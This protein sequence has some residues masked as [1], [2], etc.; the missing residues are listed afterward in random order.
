LVIGDGTDGSVT[1]AGGATLNVVSTGIGSSA[2]TV[3]THDGG[4]GEL[5]IDGAGTKVTVGSSMSIGAGGTGVVNVTGGASLDV[6]GM[7]LNVGDSYQDPNNSSIYGSGVLNISGAGTVVTVAANRI[8]LGYLGGSGELNVTDGATLNSGISVGNLGTG[9][10]VIAGAGTTVNGSVTT[11]FHSLTTIR[12]G[13]TVNGNISVN[14]GIVNVGAAP[15]EAATLVHMDGVDALVSNYGVLNLNHTG[16]IKF[17]NV[18]S[19]F[20]SNNP[21]LNTLNQIAGTTI[22]TGSSGA[23]GLVV[24]ITGGTLQIGDSTDA[25]AGLTGSLDAHVIH[26]DATLVLDRADTSGKKL[27]NFATTVDG[28]GKLVKQGVGTITL[29]GNNSYTGG[30]EINAGTLVVAADHALGA[31]SSAVTLNGGTLQV[32]KGIILTHDLVLGAN[33]GSVTMGGNVDVSGA[34]RG[35][36]SF[37]KLGTGDL[38]LSGDGT[39]FSGPTTVSAGTLSVDGSLGT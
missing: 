31:T 32:D 21:I 25:S 23:L 38:T 29:S 13:A 17:S 9:V 30:T 2:I 5:T 36:G 28:S 19:S 12:D 8:R 39:A 1:I 24:N 35:T 4:H 14:G 22:L 33:G 16:T 26:N 27:L 37:T 3:G 34:L 18:N 11:G 10:A 7:V 15:G 20:F 6:N